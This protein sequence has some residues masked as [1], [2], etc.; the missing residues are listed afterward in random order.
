MKA[1]GYD[2][3]IYPV[4]LMKPT[5]KQSDINGLRSGPFFEYRM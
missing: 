1:T 4:A 5:S 3:L 2:I